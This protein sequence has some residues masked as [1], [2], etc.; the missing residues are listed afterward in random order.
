MRITETKMGVATV[1]SDEFVFDDGVILTVFPDPSWIF[2]RVEIVVDA[3]SIGGPKMR[4]HIS[5]IAHHTGG[6]NYWR[7]ADY[8]YY[9]FTCH[10]SYIRYYK[11]MDEIFDPFKAQYEY[12]NVMD[13]KHRCRNLRKAAK[14]SWAH[15]DILR[16]ID[17]YNEYAKINRFARESL[18]NFY[19]RFLK[20][21]VL[22]NNK[23]LSWIIEATLSFLHY[24]FVMPEGNQKA[25][26]C[27]NKDADAFG[28]G[29]LIDEANGE[30]IH[31][32][33]EPSSDA[34][35]FALGPMECKHQTPHL[36]KPEL[37][38][39]HQT[40][41][42]L[43]CAHQQYYTIKTRY[44][45]RTAVRQ[46]TKDIV[47]MQLTMDQPFTINGVANIRLFEIYGDRMTVIS[48]ATIALIILLNYVNRV[49]TVMVP[50]QIK[51]I[52]TDEIST[53]HIAQRDPL[54]DELTDMIVKFLITNK[55]GL[56]AFA[57]NPDYTPQQL[58]DLYCVANHHFECKRGRLQRFRILME[59]RKLT[60]C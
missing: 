19:S 13:I 5:S 52:V 38:C 30:L 53:S 28:G 1:I 54:N 56:R 25:I 12:H 23:T 33:N 14:F 26:R 34:D 10:M 35:A 47:N 32:S 59:Q 18:L 29:C 20:L 15:Y 37:K 17:E 24:G 4:F 31:F 51:S 58:K 11:T 36:T 8:V 55:S 3:L 16:N 39:T 43:Q 41:P 49:L 2:K 57:F 6:K 27:G 40:K 60:Y 50:T 45:K 21:S 48:K 42:E 9:I 7:Y 44:N 22:K 46:Q